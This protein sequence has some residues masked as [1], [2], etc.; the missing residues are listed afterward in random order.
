MAVMLS[1]EAMS[2]DKAAGLAAHMHLI[3]QLS[4][5]LGSIQWLRC[6]QE[7]RE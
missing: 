6:D 7:F 4:R 1:A 5:D 2:K 3:Q